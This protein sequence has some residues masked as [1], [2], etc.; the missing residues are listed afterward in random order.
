MFNFPLFRFPYYNYYYPYYNKNI[1]G[2]SKAPSNISSNLDYSNSKQIKEDFEE[3]NKYENKNEKRSSK[4]NSFGP[5]NF[6]NL[7]TNNINEEDPILEILGLKLYL[8]D[9]IILGL[10][11]LLYKENVQDEMLFLALLLLLLV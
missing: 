1:Q 7:F 10:L 11:F 8:D 6:M 9:L 5:I 2:N 3:S 4:Y